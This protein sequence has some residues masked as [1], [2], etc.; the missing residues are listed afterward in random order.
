MSTNWR[1]NHGSILVASKICCSVAPPQQGALDLQITMLGRHLDGF[2]QLLDFLYVRLVAVPVEAH[3]AL[4]DG[5][6]GLAE[7]F[8]EVA[9]QSHGLAHGLHGSG[10]R[11]IGTRELFEGET[12]DLGDHVVDGRLE[13]GRSWTA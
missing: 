11:R 7:G 6:H 5:T 4:V 3:V 8:L 2:Q 13:A 9:C 1:M 10:Q 12:R